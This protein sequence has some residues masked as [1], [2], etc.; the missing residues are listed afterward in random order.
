MTVNHRPRTA[1]LWPALALLIVSGLLAGCSTS[2]AEESEGAHADPARAK[3][4]T[5]ARALGRAGI[6]VT[7]IALC[8]PPAPA[9]PGHPRPPAAVFTDTR[10]PR[11][12]DRR[13]VENG[14]VVE[15]FA[16]AAEVRERL[17]RLHA[18]AL[19]A[20]AYGFDEG[21]HALHPEHR[22]TVGGVLLRISGALSAP[23]VADYAAALH[24]AVNVRPD[25]SLL[26]ATE[27]APCST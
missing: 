22:L 1:G 11:E 15:V 24:D 5:V 20:Q 13:L 18:Q 6:P 7:D 23:A 2:A 9:P 26:H 10:V 19:A 27:E 4:V 8:V 3:A 21:G 25:I 17:R 12:H 14:G 16:S